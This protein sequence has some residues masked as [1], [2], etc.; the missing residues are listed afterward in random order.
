MLQRRPP[1][2]SATLPALA[3]PSSLPTLFASAFLT[4]SGAL[5]SPSPRPPV[6]ALTHCRP[7]VAQEFVFG[8]GRPSPSLSERNSLPFVASALLGVAR[9]FSA[10]L[11]RPSS[12]RLPAALVRL[13]SLSSGGG[14][15]PG[16]LLNTCCAPIC[17]WPLRRVSLFGDARCFS[18]APPSH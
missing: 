8:C 4:V 18:A 7:C 11:G 5:A 12:R 1:R 9:C 14:V 3:P 15:P 13:K 16:A 17:L 10:A 2:F 6:T